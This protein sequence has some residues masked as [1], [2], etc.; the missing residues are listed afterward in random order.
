MTQV[1]L[2]AILFLMPA[3]S[4]K[5][6]ESAPAFRARMES[7]LKPSPRRR[8]SLG[9]HSVGR[10]AEF[11][12]PV[13]TVVAVAYKSDLLVSGRYPRR[14]GR[15]RRHRGRPGHP[16]VGLSA[17]ARCACG[18][19]QGNGLQRHRRGHHE[20]TRQTRFAMI[21]SIV[22]IMIEVRGSARAG[23]LL[24]AAG[25]QWPAHDNPGRGAA[26]DLSE[27]GPFIKAA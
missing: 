2:A 16:G 17:T 19:H 10:W 14:A 26:C 20:A 25:T 24:G 27:A 22:M 8:M 4:P 21:A 5:W 6:D 7:S 1:I 11:T 3:P 15:T 9:L 13:T 12:A 18:A 23:S